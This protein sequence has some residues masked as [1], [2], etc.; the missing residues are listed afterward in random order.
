MKR[1]DIKIG[2]AYATKRNRE[3]TV[4]R[5]DK[6]GILPCVESWASSD[7]PGWVVELPGRSDEY[8]IASRDIRESKAE[9]ER[10][11]AEAEAFTREQN[12][13]AAALLK[14]R[15]AESEPVTRLHEWLAFR[16]PTPENAGAQ[17]YLLARN[18][19]MTL[20]AADSRRP[21]FLVLNPATAE[22]INRALG[23]AETAAATTSE[24][25]TTSEIYA[26]FDEAAGF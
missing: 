16:A 3:V 13:K 15:Q 25:A 20:N 8:W 10:R 21:A 19:T 7:K 2:K 9:Y 17:H 24:R 6:R 14:E 4:L 11:K 18:N 12:E 1:Q 22:V 26:E 5:Y 23:I